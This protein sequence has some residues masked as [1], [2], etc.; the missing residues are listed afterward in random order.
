MH[1]THSLF[2]VL[3]MCYIAVIVLLKYNTNLLSYF[4]I[5]NLYINV[6]EILP[7]IQGIQLKRVR[8]FIPMHLLKY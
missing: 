2:S 1:L 3:I 7:L 4:I 8:M 5:C 6:I